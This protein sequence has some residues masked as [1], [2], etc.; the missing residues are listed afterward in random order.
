MGRN[1]ERARPNDQTV[2][3]ARPKSARTRRGKRQRTTKPRSAARSHAPKGLP[4]RGVTRGPVR[5]HRESAG[6]GSE[7]DREG[8]GLRFEIGPS[9]SPLR[10]DSGASRGRAAAQQGTDGPHTAKALHPPAGRTRKDS[11]PRREDRQHLDAHP[12]SATQ[13]PGDAGR[14]HSDPHGRSVPPALG[15]RPNGHHRRWYE[16]T[17]QEAGWRFHA[18]QVAE[19]IREEALALSAAQVRLSRLAEEIPRAWA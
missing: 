4:E 19:L 18:A 14:V 2:Q 16:T 10:R 13:V 15:G 5:K 11:P 7:G 9:A 3:R 17:A 12:D 8:G 1:K 6:R